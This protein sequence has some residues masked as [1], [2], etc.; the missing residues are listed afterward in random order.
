MNTKNL[1]QLMGVSLLVG[2]FCVDV[3]SADEVTEWNIAANNILMKV[4]PAESDPN[5][6][7]AITHTAIYEATN[8]ITKRYGS[9]ELKQAVEPLASVQAAIAAAGRDCFIQLFPSQKTDIENIYQAALAKIS[10]GPAKTAGILVGQQSAMKTL[11]LRINDGSTHIETYRPLTTAGTYVPTTIPVLSQWHLRKPWLMTSSAQFRPSAPPKVTSD[12]Y[13]RDYNEIKLIGSKNSTHRTDDQTAIALFWEAILPTIYDGVVRSV[14]DLPGRDIT[15]NARLFMAA[16]Q[17]MDDAIIGAFDA[18]YHYN[19]WRP[20]TAIRNGD[21]DNNNVT[22]RE[23]NWEPLIATPMHPEYPCTH[24]S[25]SAAVAEVLKADIGSNHVMPVLTTSSYTAQGA[26]R[27]W[28]NV[29]DFTRE[30]AN[31]RIY[32]G[33]HFRNSTEVGTAMGKKVGELAVAKYFREK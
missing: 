12:V 9:Q 28:K 17:A 1:F 22:V 19:F 23:A 11:A 10:D 21:Q 30:V 6:A 13:A 16:S 29:E 3:T 20:I 14:A 32:D 26:K 5:R 2:L 4:S 31:A 15:Q 25:V 27:S 33:V 24:C 8:A 7:M 18:K